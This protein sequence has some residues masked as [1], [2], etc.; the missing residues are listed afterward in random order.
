MSRRDEKLR[1]FVRFA[2]DLSDLSTCKRLKVG[3]VVVTPELTEV[4]AIGYNGPPSGTSNDSCRGE[5]PCGC[6]HAEANALVKLKSAKDHL[7]LI[8][9]KSPCEHC[10]GLILNSRS[11]ESLIYVD[12]YRD[13]TGRILIETTSAIKVERMTCQKQDN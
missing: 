11:I 2:V 4:L 10:A 12:D 7:I 13:P 1:A 9:T 6:V 8:T 3:C 5:T